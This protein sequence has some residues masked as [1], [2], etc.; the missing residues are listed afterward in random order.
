MGNQ[1]K[2]LTLALLFFLLFST[3]LLFFVFHLLVLTCYLLVLLPFLNLI[4]LF[5]FP[6]IVLSKTFYLG[7]RLG[8][9][10]QLMVYTCCSVLVFNIL[11]LP[12]LLITW[13]ITSSMLSYLLSLQLV[14]PI[15]LLNLHIFGMQD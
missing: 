2:S 5:F 14:P 15:P 4:A 6:L 7:K 10:K 9:A 13:S 3:S 1:H 11:M 12:H 8:W